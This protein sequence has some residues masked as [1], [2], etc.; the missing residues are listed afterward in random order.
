MIARLAYT[1]AL[2]RSFIGFPCRQQQYTRA[3][4]SDSSCSAGM[5]AGIACWSSIFHSQTGRQ[6]VFR[7]L[8]Q[9]RPTSTSA[10]PPVKA[11][12]LRRKFWT[13]EEDNQLIKLR[14]DGVPYA[15]LAIAGRT[16][17]AAKIRLSHLAA[18]GRGEQVAA[19]ARKVSTPCRPRTPFTDADMAEVARLVKAGFTYTQIANRM[20]RSASTIQVAHATAM[21]T[22]HSESTTAHTPTKASPY[23]TLEEDALLSALKAE[24]L[25]WSEIARR[26]PYRPL[27]GLM[28]R[29]A[30]LGI[31]GEKPTQ[32]IDLRTGRF[33]LSE[34]VLLLEL[35]QKRV[36]PGAIAVRLGRAPKSIYKVLSRYNLSS[37]PADPGASAERLAA[38]LDNLR[39]QVSG[40]IPISAKSKMPK[41]R[42]TPAELLVIAE[43]GRDGTPLG[44]LSRLLNREMDSIRRKAAATGLVLNHWSKAEKEELLE[45]RHQGLSISEIAQKLGRT[46]HAVRGNLRLEPP[47]VSFTGHRKND[48]RSSDE[49]HKDRVAVSD[50][51]G[52]ATNS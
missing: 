47:E 28:G 37:R 20:N 8:L 29:A 33:R 9:F 17:K 51:D 26:L 16:I 44:Y 10:F 21:Q 24:G 36:A 12:S 11:K 18:G 42:F 46:E 48:G 41:R 1:A 40:E 2:L 14:G 39:S 38:T 32:T 31:T 45:H 30:A 15:E 4:W 23:Y 27:K 22:K 6:P 5:V 13:I 3:L 19:E 25:T 7:S 50:H 34:L 49:R 43:L 35:L 52:A